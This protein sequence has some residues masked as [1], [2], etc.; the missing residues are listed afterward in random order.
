VVTVTPR[1]S[2]H[3]GDVGT[4]VGLGDGDRGEH[5]A[6]N[7][8]GQVS[9]LLCVAARTGEVR[10]R[11]VGVN[12]DGD[13]EAAEARMGELLGED[14]RR[15][16]I[17]AAATVF[18]RVPDPEEAKLSHAPQHVSRN[19][20]ALLPRLAVRPH[21]LVDEAAHLGAQQLVLFVEVW[22]SHVALL[23]RRIDRFTRRS[24]RTP[25]ATPR[26]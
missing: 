22:R 14:R 2:T 25:R 11:H 3:R 15:E 26:R 7:N 18:D 5:L 16:G 24:A 13:G 19:F 4:G 8:A 1:S 23:S 12:E 20:T 17:G 10:R 6:G 9:P 21:D